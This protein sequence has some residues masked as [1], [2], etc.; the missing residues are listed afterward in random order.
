M[1]ALIT[2]ELWALEP[3]HS[4]RDRDCP[5]VMHI[6]GYFKLLLETFQGGCRID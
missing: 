1:F 2:R 6:A 3:V 5:L 4:L